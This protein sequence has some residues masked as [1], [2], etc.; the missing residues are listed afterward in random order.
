MAAVIFS[1]KPQY[2]DLIIKGKK[3][4][5]YRKRQIKRPDITKMIIYA[6]KPVGK[7]VGE[8][9]IKQIMKKSPNQLWAI[10]NKYSGIDKNDYDSYFN[11]CDEAVAYKIGDIIVYDIP[12]NIDEF[13]LARAPQSFAYID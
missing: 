4:Y 6:T 7:V 13:G 12:K 10:T 1:I 11:N 2:V 9:S 3:K 5:E 8:V